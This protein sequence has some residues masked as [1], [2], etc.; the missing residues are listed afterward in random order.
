MYVCVVSIDEAKNRSFFDLCIVIN[1]G[2]G[3][4]ID[5]ILILIHSFIICVCVCVCVCVCFVCWA[6]IIIFTCRIVLVVVWCECL[7]CDY[8]IVFGVWCLASV[9]VQRTIMHVIVFGC[10][11][12]G[13]CESRTNDH[14][15]YPVNGW[16]DGCNGWM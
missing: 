12:F 15:Y 16:M 5:L 6:I 10:L 9:R 14:A 2:G 7:I 13:V 4:V 11:V 1:D 8:V 3:T